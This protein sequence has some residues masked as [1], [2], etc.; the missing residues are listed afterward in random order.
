MDYTV[1]LGVVSSQGFS[2]QNLGFR[3]LGFR[4]LEFGV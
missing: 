1:L 4:V 3:C 2:L